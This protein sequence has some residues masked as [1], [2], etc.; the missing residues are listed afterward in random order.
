MIIQQRTVQNCHG[1][2]KKKKKK[3]YSWSGELIRFYY[4]FDN[5]FIKE[6]CI[7]RA[8]QPRYSIFLDKF[9]YPK[10]IIS[11]TIL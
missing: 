10:I 9:N 11:V 7:C 8:I 4:F 3:M 6:H 1:S 5:L 2:K